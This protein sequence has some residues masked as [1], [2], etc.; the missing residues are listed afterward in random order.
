M[1]RKEANIMAVETIDY[2]QDI[3]INGDSS[4]TIVQVCEADEVA[5]V[6]ATLQRAVDAY[7]NSLKCHRISLECLTN[8][9]LTGKFQVT[10]QFC[11]DLKLDA[12]TPDAPL[13]YR[14]QYHS[15]AMAI[16]T[17]ADWKWQTGSVPVEEGDV[18][19]VKH[20]AH[21]EIILYGT[22]NTVDLSTYDTWQGKVNSDTF[23]GAA[24]GYVLFDSA[25]AAPR[26][27]DTGAVTNDLEIKLIRRSV[28]W[29]QFW[30]KKTGT[31]DTLL[32]PSNAP[33]YP[34]AAFA[35]LLT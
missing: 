17:N 28:P 26:A 1:R 2:R 12:K 21:T 6:I 10:A 3:S 16:P 30:N 9:W 32:G 33:V 15:E 11:P 34:S 23:L 8:N 18:Q 19:V 14:F 4:S 27:L 22:R 5:G 24:A 25:S 29:N 13:K 7:N 20:I 35:G 31:W